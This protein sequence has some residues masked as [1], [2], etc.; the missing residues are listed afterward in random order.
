MVATRKEDKI[1]Q[2]NERR[3]QFDAQTQND[4]DGFDFKL[5]GGADVLR[6]VLN[7]DGK[8][9]PAEVE[10]GAGNFKPN[11]DPLVVRLK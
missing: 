5:R 8:P 11:E 6:F 4:L 2:E 10:V 3:I 7:I 1:E 9:R